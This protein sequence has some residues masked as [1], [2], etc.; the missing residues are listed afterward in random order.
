MVKRGLLNLKK[1][2]PTS[3]FYLW[4]DFR[5]SKTQDKRPNFV[6]KDGPNALIF[7]E[8]LRVLGAMSQELWMKTKN[9]DICIKF[10]ISQ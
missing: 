6:T 5:I 4:S 8:I 10:T 7:Q 2:K 9:I 3:S 1:S